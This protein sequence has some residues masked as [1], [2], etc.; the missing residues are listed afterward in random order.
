MQRVLVSICFGL[1]AWKTTLPLM[2]IDPP[3]ATTAACA[4]CHK[5]HLAAGGDLNAVAG[6]PNL[7][8]SCHQAGGTAA[9]RPFAARDQAL[10]W[11]GLPAGTNAIGTSHRWDANAAGHIAFLGGA[12]TASTGTIVPSGVY[13]GAYAKTYT[14]TI[15]TAGAVGSAQFGWT[16]TSPGG[17]SGANVLTATNV[18]LDQG[19]Q[20]SFI[21]GSGTSFQLNDRWNLYVR[22]DLRNPTNTVMRAHM[23][24]GVVYCSACHDQHSQSLTP[25]DPAAPVYGGAGTGNGRH[26]MRVNNDHD[27]M[28]KDCHNA[29]NVTNS[30]AGSHPVAITVPADA[31]HKAPTS[32][33]LEKTNA[34]IGC[35]T[36]HQVHH[37]SVS[38]ARLL[39]LTNNISVCIDCHTQSDTATPAAHLA[40]TNTATLWPGGKNGSLMPA[41][42]SPGDSGSCLNCHPVHGWPDAANPTN[43]YP[44]LLA[45]FEENL[46][47][48]CHGT[49]GPA[50]KLVQA[51][52][53]KTRHH[54]VANAQQVA[55][56]KVECT[57]CHNSHQA[58]AGGLNYTTTATA[59][60]NRI[61]NP[62]RGVS[63]VAV[64]YTS[65]GNFVAPAP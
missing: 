42:T 61:S 39:R 64:D 14:I 26:F 31:N 28:C 43:S 63:G 20:V 17:G 34:T 59:T 23:V 50:V 37:S 49:N 36:C 15:A 45:D 9:N 57:D 27:Q 41:R 25:F 4:A 53:S 16:A 18:A 5:P 6:N 44:K 24:N 12:T 13:T 19:V 30:I 52:F 38:D 2:A 65:L 40:T 46:C 32:L 35:L 10:P 8:M 1:L 29:R 22:S 7:C 62:L 48:T 21:N 47:L 58:T 11:P 3:H 33:P 56:R 54:P 60:R 51:D 55:G